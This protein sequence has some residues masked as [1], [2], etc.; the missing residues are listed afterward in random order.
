MRESHAPLA[1]DPLRVS[2]AFAA[3]EAAEHYESPSHTDLSSHD[4]PARPDAPPAPVP[5][6]EILRWLGGGAFGSVFLAR[7]ENTG[8]RVAIKFYAHTG[9]IDWHLLRGEVEKLALLY[10]ERDVVQL[11]Q[12]GWDSTPPYYVMEYLEGGSLDALVRRGGLPVPEAIRLIRRVAEALVRAHGRGVLHCDLKPANVLLDTNRSPRL[13]DFG[14]S[15][16]SSDQS[17]ALGTFFYMAPEQADLAAQPDARW[18]VYALGAMFYALLLGTPPHKS[19]FAQRILGMSKTLPERLSSYRTLLA[20]ATPVAKPLAVAGFDAP[21]I[22][23]VE[24]CLSPDPETRYPN[25]Q[26]VLDALDA[27]EARRARRPLFVLGSLG[28]AALLGLLALSGGKLV[29]TAVATSTTAIER[30]AEESARFA[31]QFVAETAAREIDR[32][33]AALEQAAADAELRALLTE[34]ARP[35]PESPLGPDTP[36][37]GYE[38]GRKLER[39]IDAISRENQELGATSWFLADASGLQWARS[40][41]SETVGKRWAFRDYFHGLGRDLPRGVGATPEPIHAPH[42]SMVFDSHA[43]KSRM[44][45]FSVPIWSGRRDDRDRRVLGVLGVTVE[46]GHFGELR[47]GA[48]GGARQTALLIDSKP[49]WTGQRGL[50]LQHPRL[51]D[52]PQEG[53]KTPTFRV[54][55][56]L[57]LALL[58]PQPNR[59]TPAALLS[60][61]SDPLR[62]GSG[63]RYVAAAARVVARDKDTGWVVI[64]EERLEDVVGPIS[65]LHK[66]LVRL[67]WGALTAAALIL[68]LV[69]TFALVVISRRQRRGKRSA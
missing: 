56:F 49:D 41:H 62:S 14:Q 26:A 5:G 38:V 37:R 42:R 16:M 64:V 67:G 31:A 55:P 57:T 45:A 36:G 22:E 24:R 10:T 53:G 60:S 39:W 43:T 47:P 1:E 7:E 59:T 35:T 9:R 44:V 48:R 51:L 21:L 30:R 6:Y 68:G 13:C 2:T 34:I 28:S 40:P 15:R 25:P 29:R 58:D 17:P 19:T 65:A 4:G 3:T 33:W 32:R 52:V 27:R 69:W 46:L 20:G 18:D 8:K 63:E 12:V 23:I 11:L 50:V 54:D 66:T 61:Y